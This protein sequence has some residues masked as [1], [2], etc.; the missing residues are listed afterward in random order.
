[1]VVRVISRKALREFADAHKDAETPLDD[2]YRIA[3]RLRWTS[4]VDVRRTYPHADAVGEFTIFN[5]GGDKYRLATRINFQTGKVYI[6]HMLTHE[7]YS[8]EDWKKR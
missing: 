3:K 1:M 7:E 5:I 8:R 6:R 2:W 4:I